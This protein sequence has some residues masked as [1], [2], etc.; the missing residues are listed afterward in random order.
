MTA[1]EHVELEPVPVREVWSSEADFTTWLAENMDLLSREIG[2][3][4]HLIQ[5][6]AWLAPSSDWQGRVDILTREDGSGDYVVIENQMEESDNDHFAGL[7]NYASHSD[8]R[9]LILV[10]SRIRDYHRR[11]MAWLNEGNGVRIYGVEMSA[12]R[13]RNTI[14]RRLELVAGP[15]KRSEWPEFRYPDDRLEYLDF[16]RPLVAELCQQ[17]IAERKVAKPVN[18]QAFPSGFAGI[19]YHVGFWGGQNNAS[20][21]VYLWIAAWDTDWDRSRIRNKRI[22]DALYQH[23]KEIEKELPEVGW[24]RRDSQWMSAI[25]LQNPGSIGDSN[26]KLVELRDWASDVLPKLKSTIQPRLEKIMNELQSDSR[27][28]TP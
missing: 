20:L 24:G 7:L 6:E 3:K 27:E 10:A 18:D 25:Y 23:R 15:D 2:L 21:D 22:F 26:E 13:N 14:E 12:W 9:I 8:S 5:E 11:T 17:G 19:D 4:L 28:P 16:F 1:P